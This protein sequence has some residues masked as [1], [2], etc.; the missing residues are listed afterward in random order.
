MSKKWR[1]MGRKKR[2]IL[3]ILVAKYPRA[4]FPSGSL[5]TKPLR[6]GIFT[7]ITGQNPEIS[8]TMISLALQHY[9]MKDRYLRALATCSGR[10]DL[11]GNI[12]EEILPTH[13][14]FAIELLM[15]RQ[16]KKLAA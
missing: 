15:E 1:E 7:L 16:D 12:Y 3:D 2:E 6:I 11:D 13:R 8:R 4:F 5:D 14:D 10:V 9:T